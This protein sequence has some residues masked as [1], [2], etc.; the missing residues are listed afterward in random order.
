MKLGRSGT[1]YHRPDREGFYG[2]FVDPA[3]GKRRRVLLAEANNEKTAARALDELVSERRKLTE[4][5]S[6]VEGDPD[7][8]LEIFARDWLEA[9]RPSLEVKTFRSYERN[10]EKHVFPFLGRRKLREISRADVNRFLR[11]KQATGY[12]RGET[13]SAYSRNSLRLM[14]GALS[15]VL[16]AAVDDGYL[17]L[18]PCLY[19]GGSRRRRPGA[20]AKADT[21]IN[22]LSFD[23]RAAFIGA[24]RGTLYGVPL[25]VMVRTGL[26][27]GELFALRVEDVELESGSLRVERALTDGRALKGTKTNQEREVKLSSVARR[28]LEQYLPWLREES[29]R[30]GWGEPTWLFPNEANEPLDE[31]KVRKEYRRLLKTADIPHRPL[32]ELR[33]TFASLALSEGVPVTWVSAQL[34]HENPTTTYRYYARYLPSAHHGYEDLVDGGAKEEDE[35]VTRTSPGESSESASPEVSDTVGAGGESRTRDLLITNLHPLR[36]SR[37]KKNE[38][39]PQPRVSTERLCG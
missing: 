34:G 28:L 4:R 20:I 13:R 38:T 29:L 35:S 17:S 1:V 31:S 6:L 10:L 30:Y 7:V 3:T 8:S 12:E 25:E 15:V 23:E 26:R 11:E 16:A 36:R 24:A 19:Q 18:N 37:T 32:Y 22:P 5:L 21:R 9:V 39:A 33:H 2:N 27:P 14:R